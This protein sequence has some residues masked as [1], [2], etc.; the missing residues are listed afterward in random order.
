MPVLEDPTGEGGDATPSIKHMSVGAAVTLALVDFEQ[1]NQT[2]L[3]TGEAKTFPNGDQMTGTRIYGLVVQA[4]GEVYTGLK[5]APETVNIG[6]LV[7]LWIESSRYFAWRDAKQ[8]FDGQLETGD[9]VWFALTD[10]EK[11]KKAGFN[12]RKI[13][14]AKIAKNDPAGEYAEWRTK[15]DAA[16]HNRQNTTTL[17]DPAPVPA[18]PFG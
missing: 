16:Y 15:A 17:T 18:S 9:L 3:E 8:E 13:Y 6:D 5:T 2:D 14:T 7:T 4:D 12:P 11:P 1:Y 10:T